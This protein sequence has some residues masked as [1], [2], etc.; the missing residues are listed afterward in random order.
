MRFL[1]FP[2][3]FDQNEWLIIACVAFLIFLLYKLPKRFPTSVTVLLLLFTLTV[4]RVVDHTIAGPDINFYDIMDSGKFEFFDIFCYITYAPF[5]YIF[6]YV[7]DKYKFR[8]TRLFIFIIAWSISSIIFEMFTASSYIN[9]FKYHN[10]KPIYSFPIY[11]VVQP[12]TL[13]FLH[14]IQFLYKDSIQP[15]K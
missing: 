15:K 3:D 2:R 12:F 1:P 6:V 10:W 7:Y 14:L 9:F 13:L 5:G 11:L 8:G 4:S